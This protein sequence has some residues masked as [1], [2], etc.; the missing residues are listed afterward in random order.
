MGYYTGSAADIA[1]VRTAL[2][3]ACVADG[4]TWDAGAEVLWK[5]TMFVRIQTK[6]S[7]ADT[8]LELLGKTA[9]TG[10]TDAPGVVSMAKMCSVPIAFPV[11]YFVFTFEKE[12]FFIINYSNTYQW[13]AFGQSSQAGLPGTGNWVAA[14]RG[15]SSTVQNIRIST[16]GGGGTTSVTPAF[17]WNHAYENTGSCNAWLHNNI[18]AY[19]WYLT[20][21]GITYP[22]LSSALAITE[23]LKTQ[24]N[25]F[26][27]ESVLLPV[28]AYKMRAE[29][30]VSQILEIENARH[31]RID[32][33]EPQDV[34]QLG[35][36]KW[37]VF[38]YY[39]KNV[40]VRD[41][42]LTV[43]HTGTFG[44]AIRY[45]GA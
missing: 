29:N 30:K 9:L 22:I 17:F 21:N 5:N 6:G 10:G 7:G 26:N 16:G 1:A 38:P 18:D 11:A 40:A 41:G 35:S 4:W 31:V 20:L 36:D 19:P 23:L 43:D 24:P 32:N 15:I 42:G 28:R 44:W 34:I 45:E 39:K 33:Y 3:N 25:V 2:V 12:V 8:W 27:N 37:K 14:T 13:C